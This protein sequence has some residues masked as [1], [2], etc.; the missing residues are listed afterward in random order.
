MPGFDPAPK[1]GIKP[2]DR[3]GD[4]QKAQLSS[5]GSFNHLNG[6]IHDGE[7]LESQ[8]IELD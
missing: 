5:P 2:Q 8:K 6:L 3:P 1:K 4:S 7:G